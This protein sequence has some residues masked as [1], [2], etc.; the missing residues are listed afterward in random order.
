MRMT[1]LQRRFALGGLILSCTCW[2]SVDIFAQQGLTA[3]TRIRI[4]AVTSMNDM[5]A[6]RRTIVGTFEAIGD[7][8]ITVVDEHGV[9]LTIPRPTI[10]QIERSEGRQSRGRNAAIGFA[11][12]LGVGALLAATTTGDCAHSFGPCGP[13]I[14]AVAG[15]TL[16]GGIG[17]ALGAS[18]PPAER[19][20]VDPRL[21]NDLH[22]TSPQALA[23]PSAPVAR[24]DGAR[25][26]AR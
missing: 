1:S 25:H 6:S 4:T 26:S 10:L 8:A 23:S 14:A 2:L 21:N 17:L 19:W 3:G 13:G 18:I 7:T 5:T 12:G 22:Q 11:I 20:R 16:G 24:S 9:T 15:A